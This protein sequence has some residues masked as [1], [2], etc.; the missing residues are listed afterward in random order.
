VAALVGLVAGLLIAGSTW[1]AGIGPT[2]P[3]AWPVHVLVEPPDGVRWT[4]DGST[5]AVAPDGRSLVFDGTD[6]TGTRRLWLRRFD[7]TP[8]TQVLA[9]T[10]GA[11]LPFWSPDSRSVAFSA[12]GALKKLDLSRGTVETISSTTGA[13][14]G[15]TWNDQGTIVFAPAVESSLNRVIAAGGLP[16]PLTTLEAAHG[17]MAHMWPHFLPGGQHYLFQLFGTGNSGIY[18][19]SLDGGDR[20]RLITQETFDVTSIAYEPSGYLLY[21][22]NAT[23]LAHPF[24][25]GR[26]RPTGEPIR[27]AAGFG[28]GGAGHPDFSVSRNGVLAYRVMPSGGTNQ[29]TWFDRSGL[30]LAHVGTPDRYVS[31]DL[32]PDGRTLAIARGGPSGMS[33]W[34][35]DMARGTLTRFAGEPYSS[36]PKWAPDGEHIVFSAVRD[37]PPNLFVQPLNGS[38]Q[39]FVR[40][41]NQTWA[42]DWLPDDSIVYQMISPETRGDIWVAPLAA[43]EQARPLLNSRFHESDARIS[44]DG[45]W[46]AFTSDESGEDRVYVTSFPDPGRRIP[47]STGGG[48]MPRWRGDGRELFYVSQGTLMAVSMAYADTPQPGTPDEL[49]ELPAGNRFYLAAPDG[50]RFLVNVETAPPPQSPIEVIVNWTA[51]LAR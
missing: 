12:G 39:R 35:M 40:V 29:P 9:G 33:I 36:R 3:A 24:D 13:G 50:Q 14:G 25:A 46:M 49:F 34:L 6:A 1:I 37:T 4:G 21:K 8:T 44:P 43:P 19:A 28:I 31:F 48:T 18:L 42:L 16:V 26:W 2:P 30:P 15:G 11:R 38:E 51:T 7:S 47:I 20:M 10:E 22:S 23:L 5:L 41:P 27:L 45:Q 32:S 17:E